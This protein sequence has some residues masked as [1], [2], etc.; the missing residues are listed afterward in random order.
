[1]QHYMRAGGYVMWILAALAIAMIVIAI[2]FLLKPG[3]ERLAVLRSLSWAQVFVILGGVATNL[4]TTCKSVVR[5]FEESGAVKPEI[6]IQGIGES[7]VPAGMG[8]TLLAFVWLIIALAVRKAHTP[9][10]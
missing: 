9:E 5:E 4:T 2:R 7:L 1:M 8:F 3:P 10:E 6:L